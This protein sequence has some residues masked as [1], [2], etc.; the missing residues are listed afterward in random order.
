MKH[1]QKFNNYQEVNEGW[2]ENILA[3]AM[4][5]GTYFAGSAQTKPGDVINR[6][7]TGKETRTWLQ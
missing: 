3:T 6:D 7:T 1:I 5:I 4:L 2:K